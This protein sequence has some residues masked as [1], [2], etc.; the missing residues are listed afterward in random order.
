MSSVFVVGTGDTKRAELEYIADVIRAA[1]A[2]A[3]LVDVGTTGHESTAD[4]TPAEVA[5]HHP[6]G[7][8][9]VSSS[10]RGEAVA[11][12][13]VALDAI[14][15]R[16]RRRISPASSAPAVRAAPRSSPRRCGRSRSGVPK[17]MVSTVASANVAPYVGPSDIAMMYSVTDVAGLNRIS[18]QVLGNAANA[19]AGMVANPVPASA[20]TTCRRS[21]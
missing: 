14:R 21:G 7:A 5:A 16:A 17:V 4:V 11:A 9:A 3:I 18:R 19:I 15:D 10:D 2:E 6:D 1:G 8:A 20:A 12:M 13:S